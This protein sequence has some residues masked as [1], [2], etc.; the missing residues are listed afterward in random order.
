ME[1]VSRTGNGADCCM[2]YPNQYPLEA[3]NPYWPYEEPDMEPPGYGWCFPW[4]GI[5]PPFF[6]HPCWNGRVYTWTDST[7]G[8][9]ND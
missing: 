9:R 1:Y 2:V 7:G 8:P 4:W 6:M 5:Y 3:G